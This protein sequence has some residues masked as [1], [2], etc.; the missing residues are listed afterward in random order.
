MKA[1]NLSGD[2]ALSARDEEERDDL[3]TSIGVPT[4]P[5]QDGQTGGRVGE[6]WGGRGLT[7]S[8][9]LPSSQAQLA[10]GQQA[11]GPRAPRGRSIRGR[12][13]PHTEGT[14]CRCGCWAAASWSIGGAAKTMGQAAGV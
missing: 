14:S 2:E 12:R 1:W 5:S 9:C 7:S 3:R 10:V 13:E 8:R 6:G 11:R 4:S